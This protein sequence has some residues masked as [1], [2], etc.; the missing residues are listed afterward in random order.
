MR[1]TDGGLVNE[2]G[3][4]D[5][6][7]AGPQRALEFRKQRTVEEIYIHDS[8]ERFVLEMKAIQVC[9]HGPDGEASV[10]RSRGE[11]A[12]RLGGVIDRDH[13][14]ARSRERERVAPASRRDVERDP[15]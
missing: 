14:H 6:K 4:G 15:A 11:N 7:A 9:D 1:M 10:A 3:L 5:Q 8:V 13:P 12:H 2:E